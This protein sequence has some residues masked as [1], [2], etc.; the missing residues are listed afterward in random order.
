MGATLDKVAASPTSFSDVWNIHARSLGN[1]ATAFRRAV[2]D[3]SQS[4]SSRPSSKSQNYS[5]KVTSKD[6]RGLTK[7]A[8]ART[9]ESVAEYERRQRWRSQNRK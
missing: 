5:Y 1:K 8:T 3:R 9:P 2:S 6:S 7:T 4:Y